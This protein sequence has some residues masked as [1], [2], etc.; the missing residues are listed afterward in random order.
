MQ[1]IRVILA[2]IAAA[3]P[4]TVNVVF[5]IGFLFVVRQTSQQ[6]S[7]QKPSY[8]TQPCIAIV[9]EH[10]M[11]VAHVMTLIVRL[12]HG[13]HRSLASLVCRCSVA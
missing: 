7:P 3:I 8:W 11:S 9:D 6:H 5:F 2:T 4:H 13:L 1:G 12:C 10:A